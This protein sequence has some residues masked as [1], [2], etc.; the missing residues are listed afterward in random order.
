MLLLM[1]ISWHYKYDTISVKY[2]VSTYQW[3]RE[4]T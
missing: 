4:I 1:I 3:Q 2:F